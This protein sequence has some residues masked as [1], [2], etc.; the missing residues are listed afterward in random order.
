V[1][2]AA[3]AVGAAVRE[4]RAAAADIL[5]AHFQSVR[6]RHSMY[7]SEAAVLVVKRVLV[8][9]E[10]LMAAVIRAVPTMPAAAAEVGIVR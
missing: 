7:L 9:L 2:A 10:V 8:V 1:L 5:P 4:A 6:G 3:A